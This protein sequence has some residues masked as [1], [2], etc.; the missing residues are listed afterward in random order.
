MSNDKSNEKIMSDENVSDFLGKRLEKTETKAWLTT[1][2]S[3][4]REALRLKAEPGKKYSEYYH[5]QDGWFGIR[6]M[7]PL[8]KDGSIRRTWIVRHRDADNKDQKPG[9]GLAREGTYDEA[10][11]N[12]M[13]VRRDADARR[14]VGLPADLWFSSA[15]KTYTKAGER[16]W[17]AATIRMYAKAAKNLIPLSNIRVTKMTSEMVEKLRDELEIRVQTRA[18]GFKKRRAHRDGKATALE[19]MRVVR[20]VFIDLMKEGTVQF[21][22]TA[23]MERHG[24]FKRRDAK[25]DAIHPDDLP[26]VWNWMENKAMPEVRD[27]LRVALFLAFRRSLMADLRWDLVDVKRKSY[28]VPADAEGNKAKRPYLQPIPDW[29]WTNVF[30]KRLND[31]NRHPIYVIPAPRFNPKAKTPALHSIRGSLLG[32]KKK[33]G[34]SVTTHGLRRSSATFM[35]AAVS[36]VYA[37]RLLSHRLDAT[38]TKG[39]NTRQYIITKEMDMRTAMNLMVKYVLDRVQEKAPE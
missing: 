25:A 39:Q 11:F 5:E 12:A 6:C 13:K 33:T 34:V 17:S 26:A 16:R 18:A 9:V 20:A 1:T 21:N 19:A 30:E 15:L 4:E 8:K 10:R 32:L 28:M 14:E 29:L 27:Y 3:N 2:F 23:R 31:P 38:G 24:Y 36:E 22:P 7:A 37:A 35:E